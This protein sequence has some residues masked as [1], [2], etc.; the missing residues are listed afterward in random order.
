M[1]NENRAFDDL[2]LFACKLNETRRNRDKIISVTFVFFILFPF[3]VCL[4]FL[5]KKFEL[6]PSARFDKL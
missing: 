5:N 3:L 1:C 2:L 4:Y 6:V